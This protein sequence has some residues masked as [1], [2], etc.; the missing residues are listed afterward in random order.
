LAQGH[1]DNNPE[2]INPFLQGVYDLP[3]HELIKPDKKLRDI[4][5][6][7]DP[8]YPKFIFTVSFSDHAFRCLHA[9]R[10]EDIFES[11]VIDVK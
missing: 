7:L 10:I 3:I 2:A 9:L 11:N 6:R 5:L 4:L 8:T 1:N